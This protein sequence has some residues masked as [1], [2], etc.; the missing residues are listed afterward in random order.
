MKSNGEISVRLASDIVATALLAYKIDEF[1]EYY[2]GGAPQDL[3]EKYVV[4][5]FPLLPHCCK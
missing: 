1:K 4:L 3:R 2:I 5:I